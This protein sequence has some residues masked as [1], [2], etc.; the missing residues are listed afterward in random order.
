MPDTDHDVGTDRSRSDDILRLS[1]ELDI[2]YNSALLL[3]E[4]VLDG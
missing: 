2:D 1:R 3:Y 4:A